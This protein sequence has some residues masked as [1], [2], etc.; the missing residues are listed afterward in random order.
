MVFG[1]RSRLEVGLSAP[2][3]LFK[4]YCSSSHFSFQAFTFRFH[5]PCAFRTCSKSADILHLNFLV[6]SLKHNLACLQLQTHT[7]CEYNSRIEINVC[8]LRTHVGYCTPMA[9]KMFQ[10]MLKSLD[11]GPDGKK[12]VRWRMLSPR[13]CTG[14]ATILVPARHWHFE[15]TGDTVDGT[16]HL[17]KFSSHLHASE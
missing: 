8:K 11:L 13:K 2:I 12:A 17:P 7:I 9:T 4:L 1:R 6:R 3:A 16:E 14:G 15:V 5:L 10:W